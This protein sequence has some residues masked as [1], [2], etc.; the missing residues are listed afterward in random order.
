MK[1]FAGLLACV[2]CLPLSAWGRRGHEA[3]ATL[4]L[5]DLP[6]EVAAWFRGQEQALRD[7]AS[8]PDH[9]KRADHKEG[10]RHYLELEAYGGAP[11]PRDAEAAEALLG[12]AAFRKAGQV[13]WAILDRV[14]ALSQALRGGDRAQAA[15]AASYLS[16]YVADLHVPLHTTTNYDGLAT[17]QK[18]VH[19]RWETGLVDRLAGDPEVRP[20]RLEKDL[21]QA[22]WAW[23]QA[24]HAL[25]PALLED[26]RAAAALGGAP[27]RRGGGGGS[28]WLVFGKRQGPVVREQLARAGQH[29]AQMILLAW[30]MA[31]KPVAP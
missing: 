24:T 18:G 2:L 31:G 30:S 3:V 12:P 13:P 8:E 19:S 11:V 14:R 1:V 16:H 9:W 7:H 27:G 20:A 22:P 6:P 15:L 26:D 29:T 21:A 28:Y 4:A 17:G 10:P 23:L 25:V 5:A